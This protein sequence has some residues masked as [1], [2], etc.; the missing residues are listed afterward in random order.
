ML[1]QVEKKEKEKRESR[2]D[3]LVTLVHPIKATFIFFYSPYNILHRF[4][5]YLSW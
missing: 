3:R 2:K 4:I 1:L 5:H